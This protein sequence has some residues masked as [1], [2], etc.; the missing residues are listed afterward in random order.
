MNLR[1]CAVLPGAMQARLPLAGMCIYLS[2]QVACQA[3]LAERE[4]KE[5]AVSCPVKAETPNAEGELPREQ[6]PACDLSGQHL[7]QCVL[8][9]KAGDIRG[10]VFDRVDAEN[11]DFQRAQ[12]DRAVFNSSNL[13]C[14]NFSHADLTG[15]IFQGHLASLRKVNFQG[16]KLKEATFLDVDMTGADLAGANVEDL[17]FTP[18]DLPDIAFLAQAVHLDALRFMS[19]STGLKKLRKAYL[20][21]G[22]SSKASD[23]TLA[24][25]KESQSQ[26]WSNCWTGNRLSRFNPAPDAMRFKS[27]FAGGSKD[28]GNDCFLFGVREVAFDLPSEFGS[29]PWRPIGML[30]LLVAIWTAVLAAWLRSSRP[31]RI[32]LTFKTRRGKD[33]RIDLRRF[34]RRAYARQRWE[35]ACLTSSAVVVLS[36]AF[37]LPYEE[38]DI[39]KWLRMLSSREFDIETAGAVRSFLGVLSLLCFYL[40]ALWLLIYFSDPFAP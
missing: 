5:A 36:S 11:A 20:D 40:L 3:A 1:R 30:W 4:P 6:L 2:L 9:G 27:P 24:Y 8:R 13:T 34:L 25:W 37:N 14:A 26:S 18:H 21:A 33:G 12:A 19:Y 10:K 31:P 17:Q 7:S 39:G 15:A 38:V 35:R 32:D 28:R 29:S 16:A 22:L 23:V